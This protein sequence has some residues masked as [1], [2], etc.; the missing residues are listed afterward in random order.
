MLRGLSEAERHDLKCWDVVEEALRH[1]DIGPGWSDEEIHREKIR[2]ISYTKWKEA[3]LK[4][5][6]AEAMRE[7]EKSN[8]TNKTHLI[9][10]SIDQEMPR[11]KVASLQLEVITIIREA[12][13]KCLSNAKARFEY[14]SGD[15]LEWNPHI[16]VF[17]DAIGNAGSVAQQFRRKLKKIPEVYRVHGTTKTGAIHF[18]YIMGNKRKDKEEAVQK[19]AEFRKKYGVLEIYNL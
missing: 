4:R 8:G 3:E 11:E 1:R 6:M 14:F 9:T 5:E 10:L 12:N 7:L 19:D 15:Q 2:W 13:Y 17:T 16:H 18:D